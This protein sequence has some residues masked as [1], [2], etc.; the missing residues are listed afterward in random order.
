MKQM[1]DWGWDCTI[2]SFSVYKEENIPKV[3][4]YCRFT[5][6]ISLS[7]IGTL[8]ESLYQISWSDLPYCMLVPGQSLVRMG[9]ESGSNFTSSYI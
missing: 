2:F 5:L 3:S 1:D 6:E 9:W 8:E 7:G 4:R